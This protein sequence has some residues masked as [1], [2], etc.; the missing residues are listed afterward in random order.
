MGEFRSKEG[1]IIV[2]ALSVGIS[3]VLGFGIAATGAC[4]SDASDGASHEVAGASAAGASA[5]GASAAGTAGAGA[6]SGGNSAA[7]AP[8]AGTSAGG[9]SGGASASAGTGGGATLCPFITGQCN[10]CIPDQCAT[11]G[12]ACLADT[13][14]CYTALAALTGCVCT[15]NKT[16]SACLATLSATGTLAKTVADC[17][18]SKCATECGL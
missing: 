12:A 13:S 8:S 11:E 6:A 9:S 15:P 7:G 5:A 18:K 14:G 2:R 16:I 17:A 1:F 4:S 3:A 10:A